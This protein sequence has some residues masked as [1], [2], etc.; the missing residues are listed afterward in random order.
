MKIKGAPGFPVAEFPWKGEESWI[1]GVSLDLSNTTV[2]RNN[3]EQ[4]V[5]MVCMAWAK[6]IET[7]ERFVIKKS[8]HGG[9][10]SSL[11]FEAGRILF[12][13]DCD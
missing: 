9:A 1:T 8:P 10:L 12:T 13:E 11:C 4:K 2:V 5:E 6:N 7:E 3:D